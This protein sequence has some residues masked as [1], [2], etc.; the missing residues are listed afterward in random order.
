MNYRH[1]LGKMREHMTI[2]NGVLL[3]AVLIGSSW[4]WSTIEAIQRNFKLQQQVDSLAQQIA[5]QELE[6]KSQS[7]QNQY[8]QS[9]EYLEL[10]ARERLG[11]AAPDEKLIMLPPNKV[12]VT[13]EEELQSS[14]SPITSRSNFA[15]WMYF[16]F[17]KKG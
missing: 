14:E 16:L 6:N 2:N 12:P 15:Q 11:K 9:P 3:V 13:A 5:V 1:I 17:G 4:A 7:L 10:S 8:Y